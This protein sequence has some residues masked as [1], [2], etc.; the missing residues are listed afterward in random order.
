MLTNALLEF[1]PEDE[2]HKILWDFE[3]H[4]DHQILS[5]NQTKCLLGKRKE[6]VIKG[7]LLIQETIMWK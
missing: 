6:F 5:K 3:I 4:T 1:V 7:I 2:M